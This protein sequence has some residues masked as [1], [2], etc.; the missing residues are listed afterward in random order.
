M[1]AQFPPEEGAVAA[2]ARGW[3]PSGPLSL[4][5][6]A[7][8][9]VAGL[10]PLLAVPMSPGSW[11]GVMMAVFQAASPCGGGVT[12]ALSGCCDGMVP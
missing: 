7:R 8:H 2:P 3:A 9:G 12:A 5:L 1:S 10:A 4:L 11:F 6:G